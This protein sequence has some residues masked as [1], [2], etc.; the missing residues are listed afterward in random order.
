MFNK[1]IVGRAFPHCILIESKTEFEKYCPS[2]EKMSPYDIVNYSKDTRRFGQLGEYL[3]MST[4]CDISNGISKIISSTPVHSSFNSCELIISYL[5]NFDRYFYESQKGSALIAH[6]SD[7]APLNLATGKKILTP[8]IENK[9]NLLYL[10]INSIY[11]EFFAPVF[12]FRRSMIWVPDIVHVMR[13]L[14]RTLST[15]SHFLCFEK[16]T[17]LLTGEETFN[18]G[19]IFDIK[20]IV[21][22]SAILQKQCHI[23]LNDIPPY[24]SG[25]NKDAAFRIVTMKTVELLEKHTEHEKFMG[26]RFIIQIVATI[27]QV[28]RSPEDFDFNFF[29]MIK[30]SFTMIG[31]LRL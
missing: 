24:H 7:C 26:T 27:A 22:E 4:L 10:G 18:S 14:I 8:I 21:Q 9:M 3:F 16:N 29:S 1:I 15:C 31:A 12:H 28:Y 19:S 17:D 13:T 30:I 6:V 5:L 11:C 25:M 2:I 20:Y 23:N